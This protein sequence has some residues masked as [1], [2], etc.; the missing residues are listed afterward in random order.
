VWGGQTTAVRYAT[1]TPS[2]EDVAYTRELPLDAERL[3]QYR[4]ER[5]FNCIVHA[6]RD[7]FVYFDHDGHWAS[8]VQTYLDLMQGDKRER[9]IARDIKT[10][11]LN[12]FAG[13]DRT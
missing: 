6:S 7:D 13:A 2:Q 8:D 4:D 3:T 1:T 9:E 11:I 12:R 10:Q 5:F